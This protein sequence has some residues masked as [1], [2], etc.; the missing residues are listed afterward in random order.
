MVGCSIGL[1]QSVLVSK[2]NSS[3]K[4]NFISS[5][6]KVSAVQTVRRENLTLQAKADIGRIV[7]KDSLARFNRLA[8][9]WSAG[10]DSTVAL[11]LLKTVVDELGQEMPPAIFVDHGDHY[12]ETLKMVDEVSRKWNFKVI[13]ARNEDVL[14][15]VRDNKIYISELNRRNQEEAKRLGFTGEW[16]EYS[17]ETDVGNHLLKT[18]ALNEAIER[19]E[20]DSLVVGIRWDENPARSTEVFVSRRESPAHYRVHPI[21]TFTERDIWDYM[22]KHD[23]PVHPKY[24][25]GYRSIDGKRDSKKVSDVPAW[26]QDLEHTQERVGRSQDKENMMERLRRYGYM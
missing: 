12:E 20:F 21:L 8:V 2:P 11:H 3:I 9:V 6:Q 5:L 26:E 7:I 16:I 19:Y 13:M 22:F 24:R 23:L 14:S 17:L 18:V 4:I 10:K 25:E 15:H 1:A